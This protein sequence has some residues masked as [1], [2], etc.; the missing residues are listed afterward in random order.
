VVFLVL[1][2][3]RKT[4]T[5]FDLGKF[6]EPP[7]PENEGIVYSAAKKLNLS[8]PVIAAQESVSQ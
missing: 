2:V 7:F 1:W 4:N 5:P 6:S 8:R 3:T